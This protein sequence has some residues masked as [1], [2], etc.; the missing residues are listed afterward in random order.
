MTLSLNVK[1]RISTFPCQ[2][3]ASSASYNN[4][5]TYIILGLDI[6]H[7][8]INSL[9]SPMVSGRQCTKCCLDNVPVSCYPDG[10]GDGHGQL[11]GQARPHVDVEVLQQGSEEANQ[12]HNHVEQAEPNKSS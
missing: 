10:G 4:V 12:E 7:N 6:S 3:S 5:R 11:P 2:T 9:V 8:W 1:Q